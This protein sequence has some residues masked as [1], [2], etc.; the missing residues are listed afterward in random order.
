MDAERW[1]DHRKLDLDM[2]PEGFVAWRDRALVTWQPDIRKLL[3]WA[4]SQNLTIGTTEEKK[5]AT[6]AGEDGD[7]CHISY[8]NFESLRMI[9]SGSLLS[10]APACEDGRGLELWRKLHAEWRGSAPQVIAAKAR[11]FQ[12]PLR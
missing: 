1:T 9:M 8:V 6:N 2:K 10:R 12:S 3:L 4:E 5:G 7:I 11:K